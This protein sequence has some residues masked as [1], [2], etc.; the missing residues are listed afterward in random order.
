MNTI[1][2]GIGVAASAR[3][4]N[5]IGSR[6]AVGA[7]YAAHASALMSVIV[8][9]VVMVVMIATKDVR[10]SLCITYSHTYIRC[11]STATSS[12]MMKTSLTLSVRSCPSSRPSRLPMAS[13]DRAVV[14]YVGKV[15]NLLVAS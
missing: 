9:L 15:C 14:C 7:K 12:V 2:F 13:L 8:G 11:R 4:G 6:S 5:L 3:V 1:P 10:P